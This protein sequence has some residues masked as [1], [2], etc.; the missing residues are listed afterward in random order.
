[1][2]MKQSIIIDFLKSIIDKKVKQGITDVRHIAILIP[3]NGLKRIDSQRIIIGE[4][5]SLGKGRGS[6]HAEENA[7]NK[8]KSIESKNKKLIMIVI[9]VARSGIIGMSRPCS[10][11]LWKIRNFIPMKG[12][13]ISR[14]I[15]SNGNNDTL[16][17]CS[18]YHINTLDTHVSSYYK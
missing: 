15:Y 5:I 8:L 9:R 4:N 17:V 16:I 6:I 10:H 7:I 2:N 3:K 18:N 14:L 12:Y 1:M 11:C 13:K